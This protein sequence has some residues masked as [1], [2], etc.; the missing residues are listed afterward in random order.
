MTWIYGFSKSS[1]NSREQQQQTTE[2]NTRISWSSL[3]AVD[4]DIPCSLC[5]RRAEREREDSVDW[6]SGGT[7]EAES[8][9]H[10][11]ESK[12]TL[13]AIATAFY[14]SQATPFSA[15]PLHVSCQSL[16]HY[17]RAQS[18]TA[19]SRKFSR[20]I[21]G[22]TRVNWI[23]DEIICFNID[24]SVRISW[25]LGCFLRRSSW[26]WRAIYEV[27]IETHYHI[28]IVLFMEMDQAWI[29]A[30]RERLMSLDF[31]WQALN[32]IR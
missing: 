19:P 4:S 17:Y 32:T 2:Q 26:L 10:V 24:Q 16:V 13:T 14:S 12:H 5:G 31:L 3:K 23:A 30:L 25:R 8:L 21:N 22:I 1:I 6:A 9:V 20:P 11:S 28:N 27:I 18:P 15:W 29:S 7:Q